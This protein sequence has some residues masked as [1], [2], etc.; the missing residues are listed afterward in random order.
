MKP[1]ASFAVDKIAPVR[2]YM[3]DRPINELNIFVVTFK[4]GSQSSAP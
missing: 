1:W 3:I 4:N 2:I